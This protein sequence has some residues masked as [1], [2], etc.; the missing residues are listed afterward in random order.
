MQRLLLIFLIVVATA[1][2]ALAPRPARAGF[3]DCAKLVTLVEPKD[4]ENAYEF[5]RDYGHCLA[6]LQ[7]PDFLAVL[8]GV[9]LIEQLAKGFQDDAGCQ[10]ALGDV[11]AKPIALALAELAAV[12]GLPDSARDELIAFASDQGAQNFVAFMKSTPGLDI[13]AN[14]WSCACGVRYSGI[15]EKIKEIIEAVLGCTGGV[16]ES[17]LDAVG[18]FYDDLFGREK[19]GAM[20]VEGQT[21]FCAPGWQKGWAAYSGQTKTWVPTNKPS[22]PCPPPSKQVKHAATDLFACVCPGQNA[23]KGAKGGGPSATAVCEPCQG[24]NAYVEMDGQC[25]TC[26]PGQKVGTSPLAGKP[27]CVPACQPGHLLKNGQCAPCPAGSYSFTQPNTSLGECKLCPEGMTSAAGANQCSSKCP[28]WGYWDYQAKACRPF[29]P[30]GKL[31]QKPKSKGML[32]CQD[33]PEGQEYRFADNSCVA[34]PK[35]MS[36]GKDAQGTG[37]CRCPEGMQRYGDSCL[38]AEAG[39]PKSPAAL[40]EPN[41]KAVQEPPQPCPMGWSYSAARGKCVPGLKSVEPPGRGSTPAPGQSPRGS[42]GGASPRTVPPPATAPAG[43]P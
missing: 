21:P 38:P 4:L 31:W 8:A 29:C 12:L 18:E 26:S 43:K 2:A 17:G 25:A 10:K 35:G 22:C 39:K 30:P 19:T 36:W 41:L 33:C 9:V 28:E 11:A 23:Y 37:V 1:A 20:H 16:L 5:M 42:D 32:F 24:S 3:D 6:D 7:R 13:I 27:G 15:A 40:P 14:N 34:C